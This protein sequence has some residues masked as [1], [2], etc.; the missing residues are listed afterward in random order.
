MKAFSKCSKTDCGN[1]RLSPVSIH[2]DVREAP[3]YRGHM[4]ST[5]MG[6]HTHTHSEIGLSGDFAP[7]FF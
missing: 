5:R 3:L 4:R 6:T 2:S 1:R 7:L